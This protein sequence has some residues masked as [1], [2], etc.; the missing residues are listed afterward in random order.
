VWRGGTRPRTTQSDTRLPIAH[1][2]LQ[3]RF[4]PQQIGGLNRA[5][6]GDITYLPTHEGWLYLAIVKDVFS[7]R[8]FGWSLDSTLEAGL[9]VGAWQRALA[10]RGFSSEQGSELYHSDRGSQYCGRWFQSLL[11]QSGTQPSMSGRGYCLDNAVAGSVFGTLKAELLAAQPGGRFTSKAQAIALMGDH[12][13]NFYNRVRLHYS[14]GY[15]SPVVFEPVH[16]TA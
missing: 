10:T 11:A 2:L 16:H 13:E 15:R 4:R 3:R 6:C 1:N 12:T 14:P 5:W 7:R 9:V 8:I